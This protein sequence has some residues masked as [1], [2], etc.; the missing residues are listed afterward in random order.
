MTEIT[1]YNPQDRDYFLYRIR[2]LSKSPSLAFYLLED[3]SYF[4][5]VKAT[6]V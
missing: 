2:A 6:G 3:R 1:V 5:K 4:Q